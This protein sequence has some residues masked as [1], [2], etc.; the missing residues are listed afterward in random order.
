MC[1][2]QERATARPCLPSLLLVGS[3]ALAGCEGD[4]DVASPPGRATSVEVT[5]GVVVKSDPALHADL[6]EETRKKGGAGGLRREG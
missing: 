6:G 2:A 4:K 1:N 3:L 5:T